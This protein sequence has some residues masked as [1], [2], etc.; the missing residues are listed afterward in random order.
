MLAATGIPGLIHVDWDTLREKSLPYTRLG[1]HKRENQFCGHTIS[2]CVIFACRGCVITGRSHDW[3]E[4]VM[5]EEGCV[6]WE[7]TRLL[8]RSRKDEQDSKVARGRT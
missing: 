6:H 7:C 4:P 3:T 5:K 2:Y 1:Y 8:A